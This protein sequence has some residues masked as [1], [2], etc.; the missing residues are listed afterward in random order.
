MHM[1]TG[2]ETDRQSGR[3]IDRLAAAAYIDHKE[4]EATDKANRNVL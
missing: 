1:Y 2:S 3:Q 4:K